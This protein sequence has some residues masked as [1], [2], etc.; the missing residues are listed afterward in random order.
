MGENAYTL[1]RSIDDSL[2]RIIGVEFN[3][4]L[5]AGQVQEMAMFVPNGVGLVIPRA[6]RADGY[7][8]STRLYRPLITFHTT[9]GDHTIGRYDNPP[10]W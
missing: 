5:P 10:F 8:D 1:D 3:L 9:D 4:Q 2:I 6:R 7:V